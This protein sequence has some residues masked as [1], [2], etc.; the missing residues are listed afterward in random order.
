MDKGIWNM[1][2]NRLSDDQ[3]NAFMEHGYVIGLP[4]F[5]TDEMVQL[6]VGLKQLEAFLKPNETHFHMNAWHNESRWLYDV[7][8]H[9]QILNYVEDILGPNFYL[10]GSHFF[11]KRP[12]SMDT[13]GWHQD[14]QYWPLKP[15][16]SVTV[17]LAFTEVD[18]ENGAMKVIPGTHKAGLIKHRS[19]TRKT[20]SLNLVM[21]NGTY[22]ESEAVSLLLKA[23]CISLHDD[24]LVHSSPANASN[25]F[26]IGLTMRFSSTDVKC[27]MEEWPEFSIHVVRG[28]DVYRYNPV[29]AVPFEKFSRYDYDPHYR[30]DGKEL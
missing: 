17:W 30:A 23:G 29:R 4:V 2:L 28:I 11:A 27:D 19:T 13:V 3:K 20:D 22:N 18:E 10:W 7:C 8:T 24:A 26:R 16:N 25:R 14:A 9:P 12:Q 21:E 15:H 1:T 5:Q 6:N